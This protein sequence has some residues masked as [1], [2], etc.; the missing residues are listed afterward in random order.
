[1]SEDKAKP[2][3]ATSAKV[4]YTIAFDE[5]TFRFM[6]PKTADLD[7]YLSKV[8]RGAVT[9]GRQ[10]TTQLCV[11]EDRERWVALLDTHPGRVTPVVETIMEDLGFMGE[12]VVLPS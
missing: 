9:A 12:A 8:S 5:G 2:V 7:R 1:M 3:P 6:K 10:F 4:A 11:P